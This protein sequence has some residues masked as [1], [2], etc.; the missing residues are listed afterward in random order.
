MKLIFL[1]V[2]GT[3]A[4]PGATEPPESAA[5]AV[6][7]ARAAGNRVF[8]CTGRNYAMLAPFLSLG[9]DGYIASAG[10]YVVSGDRVLFDCPMTDNQRDRVLTLL[11]EHGI[12]RTV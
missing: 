3:F 7:A 9:F 6:R 1:D 10:G 2:D 8:L 5:E 4:L 12:I 11:R